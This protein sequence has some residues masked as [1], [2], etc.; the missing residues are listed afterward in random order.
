MTEKE[1]LHN[2]A[3]IALRE[4][5]GLKAKEQVLIVIDEPMVELGEIFYKEALRQRAE[6]MI[7]KMETRENH[8]SEPP[9]T[10]AEAMKASDVV[11]CVTSKSLSHTKA[12]RKANEAGTRVATL[13]ALTADMM[14][15]TLTAN[16]KEIKE[17]SELYGKILTEGKQV[18]I[19]TAKGTDLTMDING[20]EGQPD[21]GIYHRSGQ[22]GNLPA[23]EAYIAPVE[24]TTNGKLVIDGAMSGLGILSEPLEITVEDGYAI[25]VKGKEA[26]KLEEIFKRYGK[27]A[28]NIA[29]LGIGTNDKAKLTGFVLEDEKVLGTI[30]VAVGDNSTFGGKVQVASHL[31]GIITE[32]TV[33]IDGEAIIEKG[34]LLK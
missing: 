33:E 2:A 13:P 1:Q 10:V 22:F 6:A 23:G 4:C 8:G 7:I 34:K 20:R 30:H 31:D 9:T 28:R 14:S 11:L 29:E 17:R 24:G 32:P 3:E 27:D 26:S 15:R 19:T 5:M 16:Y 25:A 21:T 18:R 12:R